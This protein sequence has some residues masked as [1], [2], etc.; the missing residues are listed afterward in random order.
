[1]IRRPPRSTRTDTLCPYTTLFRS[2]K[3]RS[4]AYSRRDL[5]GPDEALGDPVYA[6]RRQD[7]QMAVPADQQAA[8]FPADKDT[9]DGVERGARAIGD[10]LAPQRKFDPHSDV[11]WT[12]RLVNRKDVV[13]GQS[14]SVR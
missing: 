9:A 3:R 6:V 8:A 13:E 2:C 1:M 12:P 14:V 7:D 11:G 10:I 5:P 4:A